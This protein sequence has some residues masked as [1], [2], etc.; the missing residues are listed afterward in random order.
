MGSNFS[1]LLSAKLYV[2][3]SS[4]YIDPNAMIGNP[5]ASMYILYRHGVGRC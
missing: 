2:A 3:I 1:G 5:Y 4:I